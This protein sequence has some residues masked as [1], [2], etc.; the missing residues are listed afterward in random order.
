MLFPQKDEILIQHSGKLNLNKRDTSVGDDFG[1]NAGSADNNFGSEK[2][3]VE[4]SIGETR[5]SA[6]TP[7]YDVNMKQSYESI[8]PNFKIY[9][10][11]FEP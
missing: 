10:K 2:T 4:R 8:D 5:L 3:N 1:I 9:T 6:I 11:Q 7:L